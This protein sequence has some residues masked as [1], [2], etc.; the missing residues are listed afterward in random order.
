MWFIH[1]LEKVITLHPSYLG[2]R[3]REYIQQKLYNDVEGTCTGRFFIVAVMDGI[4]I[5]PG[6]VLPGY[7]MSQ[8]EVNY[9]AIVFKPFKG[10]VLD[11]KVLSVDR[12]GVLCMAGPLKLFV[13]QY[14]I[15][16]AIQ[17][18]ADATPPKYADLEEDMVIEKGSW[19]RVKILGI[20]NDVADIRAIGTVK[21]DYLGPLGEFCAAMAR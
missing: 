8:F 19:L 9:Q 20:K 7:G 6:K 17:Y 11:A 21:E 14:L 1:R 5:S 3:M 15:P 12:Q 10:E 18:N 2:P 16:E 13:S 4:D